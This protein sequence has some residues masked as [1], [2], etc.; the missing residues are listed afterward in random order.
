ME[1]PIA[2][3]EGLVGVE[4]CDFSIQVSEDLAQQAIIGLGAAL[5]LAPGGDIGEGADLAATRQRRDEH[6][7]PAAVAPRSLVTYRPRGLL[8]L[9]GDLR[10]PVLGIHAERIQV[11][12]ACLEAD[13]VALGRVAGEQSLRHP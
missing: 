2:E 13:D 9:A 10:D 3:N 6:V 1:T 7:D 5:H 11:T 4:Y 8:H 12:A